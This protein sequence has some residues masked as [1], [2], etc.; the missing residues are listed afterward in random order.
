[1][2]WKKAT[3]S[4]KNGFVNLAGEL[5]SVNWC[6][7]YAYGEIESIHAREAVLRCGSDD[8]IKIWVN[9]KVVHAKEVQRGYA[10]NSDETAVQLKAG[11]NRILLKVTN[12]T[13]GWG[14]WQW[15]FR[16]RIFEG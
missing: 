3:A 1:M 6:V 5:G 13:A 7:A 4:R 16:R 11:I 9:G 8:G 15:R 12:A 14:V 2:K 10:P